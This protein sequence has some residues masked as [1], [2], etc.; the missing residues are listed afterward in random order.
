MSKA[1]TKRDIESYLK[2]AYF[3]NT[4]LYQNQF[5]VHGCCQNMS[6]QL[7][8]HKTVHKPILFRKRMAMQH[9]IFESK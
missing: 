9:A 7:T 8:T 5:V 1:L 6:Q 3:L 4:K 2:G